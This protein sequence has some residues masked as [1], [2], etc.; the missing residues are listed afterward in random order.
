MELEEIVK[1]IA[2][3]SDMKNDEIEE[4]IREKQRELGGLVTS[5]GAA[6]IIANE[7][8]I[9]LFEGT[10][11]VSELKIENIIPG[12]SNVDVVGRIERIFP[13]REFEKKDGSKGKVASLILRDDTGTIRAV[14]WGKDTKSIE[15]G[16]IK[17]G[18]ILRLRGG[19]TKEN[20]NGEPEVHVGTR[21]RIIPNP[22]D[23]SR[24]EFPIQENGWKKTISELGS[25]MTRVDVLCKVLRIYEV[26]EFDRKDGS[27]GR[28]VNLVV[29][30]GTGRTRLVL[31]DDDVSLVEDGRL[32]EG[33]VI[34]IQNGYIKMNLDSPEINL[35]RYGKVILNPE[36]GEDL[37]VF[38]EDFEYVRKKVAELKNKDRAEIRGILVD[39]FD[40]RVFSRKDGRKGMVVNGVFDDGTSSIGAVFYDKVA[41]SLTNI[42]LERLL[43]EDVNE[44]WNERRREIVGKEIILKAVVRYSDFSGKDE[45]IVNGVDLR[46]DPKKEARSLLEEARGQ[47]R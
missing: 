22:G 31:W 39:I 45:L 26:R 43:E 21:T 8:G 44:E 20:I 36:G 28:V 7:I 13:L 19:Y 18:D 25:E 1:K 2:K 4:R 27:R 5:E 34:Q 15:D 9:N 33:D 32:R 41:E 6:H 38:E 35:G 42:P 29:A 37:E 16:T 14:F 3:E 23:I 24:D 40:I 11:R 30:D 17:T 10:P 12:M 47:V 46:P